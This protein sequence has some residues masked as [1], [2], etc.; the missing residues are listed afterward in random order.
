MT[1]LKPG[2]NSLEIFILTYFEITKDNT[3]SVIGNS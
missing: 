2:D 3:K 1:D